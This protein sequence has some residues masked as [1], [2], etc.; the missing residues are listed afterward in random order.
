MGTQKDG[1]REAEL[2]RKGEGRPEGWQE[3]EESLRCDV[4][5][6]YLGVTFLNLVSVG[7]P[8]LNTEL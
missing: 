8:T 1:G 4:L 5:K 2:K 6:E 3:R 7:I